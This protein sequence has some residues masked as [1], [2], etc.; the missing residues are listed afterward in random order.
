MFQLAA[1]VVQE[2]LQVGVQPQPLVEQEDAEK[3][4]VHLPA[5]VVEADRRAGLLHAPL[6]GGHLAPGGQV[7]AVPDDLAQVEHHAVLVLG[8]AFVVVAVG[9]EHVGQCPRQPGRTGL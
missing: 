7:A 1:V 4:F 8:H 3:Q 9:L 2:R 5:H 6:G